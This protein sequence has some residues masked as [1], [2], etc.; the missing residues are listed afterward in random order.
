MLVAVALTGCSHSTCRESHHRG[1]PPELGAALTLE[2]FERVVYGPGPGATFVPTSALEHQVIAHLVP[3]L[4]EWSSSPTIEVAALTAMREQANAA[5]FR[6]ALWTVSGERYIALLEAEDK[7]RGAGAYIFRI[8]PKTGGP[9]LVLEAPHH[10]YDVGTG[11]LAA[12]LFF[13]PKRGARPRA[14]FTNTIHRYQRAP[15]DKGKRKDNPAD[16]A[17][18]REH[19][20]SVATQAFAIAAEQARV[21]QL[22]GFGQRLDGDGDGDGDPGPIAVVVSAGDSD[23]SSPW[24]GAVASAIA[25][26]LGDGMSGPRDL[27]VK[28]YPEDTQVLGATTNVQGQLLRRLGP[29]RFVHVEM[30]AEFRGRLARDA[31]LRGRLAAA[32]FDP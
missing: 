5:G 16:V 18:N 2:D 17:H 6:I 22:H 32:L 7:A 27:G 31:E 10:Y 11:T 12:Q 1:T 25:K 30:S 15:G 23:G 21:I 19:A 3:E 13:S 9:V 4:L 28:R 20:F 24:S 14:L 26:M 8:G 29:D